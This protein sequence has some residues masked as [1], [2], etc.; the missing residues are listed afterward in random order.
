MRLP[1]DSRPTMKTERLPEPELEKDSFAPADAVETEASTL[2]VATYNIRYAVGP[3]LI[4]GGLLRRVGISLAGRRASHVEHN[5][6]KASLA[7]TDG[8]RMPP[9]DLI[10]L[11]EADRST[12]R[13]GGRHVARELARSLKM[14]Y[15]RAGMATPREE[16]PKDKQWYLN[17]EETLRV[18]EEGDTG[19]AILSRWPLSDA[20]RVELPWSECAW[21]PR[22][23]L[24][25]SVC[26]GGK[27]LHV[28]NSHIDPHAGIEEQLQQHRAVL[29]RAES[30]GTGPMVLLGDFNTLSRA[31]RPAMRALLESYGYTTP[32]PTGTRTWHAGLLRLHADWIFVRGVRVTRWGVARHLGVSDHWPVWAEIKLEGV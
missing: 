8:R 11:Q 1:A 9:A 30:V 5:I 2:V 29:A 21:R 13:A 25:A 16:A 6:V 17:F 28:F 24:A 18:G 26:L 32:I 27:R 20:A 10:A 19:V 12:V 23:A 15:V 31:S 7:L 14:H 4:S 22:L 3:H